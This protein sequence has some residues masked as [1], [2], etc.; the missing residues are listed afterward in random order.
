M[1]S[2][3]L[4]KENYRQKLADALNGAEPD[5]VVTVF[6]EFA[7]E[8]S[9]SIM[10]DVQAYQQTQDASILARRGVRQLTSNEKKF[11]QS[12]I[13]LVKT[14]DIKQAFTGYENTFPEE[15]VNEVTE[16]I[17][18]EFP[19][20]NA[21][22]FVTARGVIR[23]ILKNGSS[24]AIATWGPLTDTLKGEL[25]AKAELI[26]ITICKVMAY[27]PIAKDILDAGIVWFDV[28]ARALIVEA[29][30]NAACQA[31]VSGTGKNEPIGMIRNCSSTAAVVDGVY[32]L[33]TAKKITD[34]SVKTM[35]DLFSTLA[36]D[37][38]GK[39]RVIK[40]AIF[41]CNPV[42]FYSK[43]LPSIAY[44]NAAGEWV[45]KTPF[46]VDFYEEPT[47]DAGKAV[48]GIEKGYIFGVGFGGDK[49]A[50]DYD[51]SV[52]LF[53]DER[54]YYGKM[55]ANGMPKDAKNFIYLD[56]SKLSVPAEP[57]EP[58]EE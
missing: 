19:L 58:A 36:V 47:V 39:I 32:P 33:Q 18:S 56:I 40:R 52:R 16:N 49:G 51:D 7:T 30:G 2:K 22:D 13:N 50:I 10:A 1:K 35:G 23:K 14:G 12:F 43:V 29:L 48:I 5:G 46:P 38:N 53:N 9:N 27:L 25:T 8:L 45:Y 21:L 4:F 15:W 6:E 11:Y 44:Q 3:D 37:S 20:I 28:Y 42:D 31:V 24:A 17:R 55:H 41:V 26:D 57:S 34:L 54:V